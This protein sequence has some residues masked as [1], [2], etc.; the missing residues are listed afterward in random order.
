MIMNTFDRA[1]LLAAG[2]DLDGAGALPDGT[3]HTR[4]T[5]RENGEILAEYTT[6]GEDAGALLNC[7]AWQ[8]YTT[9]QRQ[10]RDDLAALARITGEG[11][12]AGLIL[13][14]A[15]AAWPP[16]PIPY[17]VATDGCGG[18][19]SRRLLDGAT[20]HTCQA[21]PGMTIL[22]R[23]DFDVWSCQVLN[24]RMESLAHSGP[25]CDLERIFDVAFQSALALQIN[26]LE[27]GAL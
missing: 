20:L 15:R 27:R 17:A 4:Y 25:S 2:F 13:A 16:Q 9:C 3:T 22:V 7:A 10:T 14:E 23:E 18:Y 5:V 8:Q 24:E 12:R 26:R 6:H 11:W 1:A 19:E 21:A